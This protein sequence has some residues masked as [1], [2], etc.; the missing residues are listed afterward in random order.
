MMRLTKYTFF[1]AAA[2]ILLLPGVADAQDSGSQA[3]ISKRITLRVD[4]ADLRAALKML[5]D[6]AGVNYSLEQSVR[7]TVTV[8]LDNIP[9]RTALESMLRSTESVVPLTYRVEDGVYHIGPRVEPIEIEPER[10]KVIAA[11]PRENRQKVG[12]IALNWADVR[13]LINAFGGTMIESRA[14]RQS[15]GGFGTGLGGFGAANGGFSGSSSGFG[16]G[17]GGGGFFGYAPG[18]M[19][20]GP[21]TGSGFGNGFN[22]GGG[23]NGFR[24]R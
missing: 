23:F 3:A 13:D 15:G 2:V 8:S 22:Q 11:P 19:L 7:G 4:N 10:R 5:F 16:S 1:A 9:F 6:S 12:K 17:F 24:G 20:M 18:N 21:F 14:G